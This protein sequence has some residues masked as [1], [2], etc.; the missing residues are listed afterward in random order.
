M[1]EDDQRQE[2]QPEHHTRW[3]KAKVLGD[4]P[5]APPALPDPSAEAPS[6]DPAPPLTPDELGGARWFSIV[7]LVVIVPLGLI[8]L[9]LMIWAAISSIPRP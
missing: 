8:V 9:V 3:V 1:S 5:E 7:F 2:D 6:H 4:E